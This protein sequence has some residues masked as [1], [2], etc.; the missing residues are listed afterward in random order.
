MTRHPQWEQRLHDYFVAV[1]DLPHA[2]G[3]HDCLLHAANTIRAVTGKDPARGHR[4]KY[5]SQASAVRYLERLGHDSPEAMLDSLLKQKP[6]GFAQRGDIVL[7]PGNAVPG[8]PE[9]WAI[10]ATVF[11][12]ANALVIA[13]GE[14]RQGLHRIPRGQWLKAYA[15]GDSI[16]FGCGPDWRDR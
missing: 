6:V 10:P 2:Y 8:M 15:V 9:G 13:D 3:Q 5:K 7:V 4:R 14:E 12:G 16:S 11:D 1:H